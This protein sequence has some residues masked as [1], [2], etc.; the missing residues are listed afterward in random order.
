MH[1][2][3]SW[4]WYIVKLALVSA[5]GLRLVFRQLDADGNGEIDLD[6]LGRVLG[7]GDAALPWPAVER[8]L[9]ELDQ[10]GSGTLAWSEFVA[11]TA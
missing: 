4:L 5:R 3:V 10:D 11:A 2:C 9:D 7:R 6:E 1:Y 8:V